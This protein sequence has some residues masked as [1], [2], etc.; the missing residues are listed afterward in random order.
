MS[1]EEDNVIYFGN[2]PVMSYVL[3]VVTMFSND[4]EKLILRA[5]GRAISRA[6]DTAEVVRQK[7]IPD[8]QVKEIEIG[9]EEIVS[10]EGDKALVSRKDITLLLPKKDYLTKL[11][12]SLK[13]GPLKGL[14]ISYTHSDKEF[15]QRLVSDLE[16][17][18]VPVWIDEKEHKLGDSLIERIQEGIDTMDYL[19]IVLSPESVSSKW[20]NKEL[21]IAMNQEIEGKRVKV[22][23]LLYRKCEIPSFLKDKIYANF[24][25]EDN[26]YNGLGKIITRIKE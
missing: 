6:V 16:K 10:E 11:R 9:T 1:V 14:F 15:V 5:R 8:V 18:Q 4:Y 24:T 22:L 21:D 26:Y 20:V 19:A 13:S 12:E 23:P 17:L 3:A 2:K 7:F 25:T